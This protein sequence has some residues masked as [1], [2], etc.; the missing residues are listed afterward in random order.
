MC[1]TERIS[2]MLQ[3]S[4]SSNFSFFSL[5]DESIGKGRRMRCTFTGPRI[6]QCECVAVT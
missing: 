6:C 1:I 2:G 3:L 5:Y 4:A